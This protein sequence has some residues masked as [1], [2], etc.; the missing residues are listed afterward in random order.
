MAH[1]SDGGGSIRVPASECGLVGLKPSRGRVSL[2]PEYGEYWHGLVISHVVC[3]SVRDT[4]GIL[5]AVAGPMP[6][7]PYVAPAPLRP[8]N[9]HRTGGT[10]RG[11]WDYE[12]GGLADMAHHQ[13]H[14]LAYQHG[15]D[16]TSPVEITAH[17]PPQHPEA[18]G[19]WGWVELK[20]ADGFMLVLDSGDAMSGPAYQSLTD[21]Q[22]PPGKT[23]DVSLALTAPETPGLYRGN[24]RLRAPNGEIFGLTTG[25]P[26][27]VEVKVME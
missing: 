24:W 22:V 8:Y 6:G 11:Y 16:L 13:L 19:M 26:F 20:Y 7:D 25:N 27:W 21:T 5:D 15:R 3:R 23:L 14:G 18:V 17:A 10:H 1:A 2:G 12:G 4:A 9:S